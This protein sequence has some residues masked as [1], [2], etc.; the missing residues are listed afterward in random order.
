MNYDFIIYGSGISGKITTIAL[1]EQGF[2]VC[3][4]FDKNIDLAKQNSNLVTFLSAGSIDYLSPLL[5][6]HQHLLKYTEIKEIKCQLNS[7]TGNKRQ[8]ISFDENDDQSLGRIVKNVKLEELLDEELKKEKNIDIKENCERSSIENI[9]N[10]INLNLDDGQRLT[11]RLFILSSSQNKKIL[12]SINIKFIKKDLLQTALSITVKGNLKNKNRAFQY[13]TS[14]GPLAILPYLDNEAS[15]VWSIKNSSK[16]LELSESEIK[17]EIISRVKDIIVSPEIINLERHHLKF[18]FAKK[19]TFKNVVL[20]GNI[21]HNIHPIA[22]QGLNLNIK[23]IAK[24]TRLVSEFKSIGYEVNSQ[25]ILDKFDV[26]RKIDNTFY[27]F[28]TLTLEG[29]LTSKNKLINIAARG[30]FKLIQRSRNLKK[31]FIKSATGKSFFN[32]F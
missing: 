3:L 8:S 7:H 17:K 11:S 21:A 22:G 10:G 6:K 20:L 19:L 32:S 31:L 9:S 14:D 15:I 24:F 16:I 2:H 5:T 30:G 28:G 18:H 29:I 4:I 26:E 27:S 13:F 12:S 23:D 1:A 25:Q